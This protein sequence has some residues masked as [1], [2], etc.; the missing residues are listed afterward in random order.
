MVGFVKLEVIL[1]IL[2]LALALALAIALTTLWG[3]LRVF[4]LVS[5]RHSVMVVLHPLPLSEPPS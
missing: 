4:G 5:R 3:V 1:V 2:A